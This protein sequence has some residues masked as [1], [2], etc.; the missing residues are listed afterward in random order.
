MPELADPKPKGRQP[1]SQ[2]RTETGGERQN[3]FFGRQIGQP[4]QAKPGDS[5]SASLADELFRDVAKERGGARPCQQVKAE[6]ADKF[7]SLLDNYS[8]SVG[9]ER[10]RIAGEIRG[11]LN[12]ESNEE[13]IANIKGLANT[14]DAAAWEF[15]GELPDMHV[16]A[17]QLPKIVSA[18]NKDEILQKVGAILA[19]ETDQGK[20]ANAMSNLNAELAGRGFGQAQWS[21]GRIGESAGSR[22]ESPS[23]PIDGPQAGGQKEQERPHDNLLSQMP[24]AE[25]RTVIEQ[26]QGIRENSERAESRYAIPAIERERLARGYWQSDAQRAVAEEAWIY[27]E[28]AIRKKT[29]SENDESILRA[30]DYSYRWL[31]HMADEILR[32]AYDHQEEHRKQ[33]ILTWLIDSGIIRVENLGSKAGFDDETIRNAMERERL[34]RILETHFHHLLMLATADR[35]EELEKRGA[36]LDPKEEGRLRSL[37]EDILRMRAQADERLKRAEEELERLQARNSPVAWFSVQSA[38]LMPSQLFLGNFVTVN[39]N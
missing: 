5:A 2:K 6:N 22:T 11:L 19:H 35:I 33:R 26:P 3:T 8:S 18:E 14:R 24:R 9:E 17:F 4:V 38:S 30:R 20:I 28:R 23:V 39:F 7:R 25:E 12:A 29:E 1:Q 37:Q 36:K 21:D 27:Y 34:K 15:L 16:L 10:T 32:E 31:R 13:R